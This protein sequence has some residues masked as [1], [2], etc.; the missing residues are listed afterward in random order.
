MN[1][2]WTI[3]GTQAIR[4]AERDGARLRKY[5][6]PIEG[7][8]DNLTGD[9]AREICRRDPSLVYVVV[10]HVGW[11]G[12][13][14]GANIADYFRGTLGG[15]ARSGATYLGPDEDELEPTWSDAQ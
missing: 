15:A 2:I 14:T 12:D 7:Y 11:T 13:A 4:I 9:E 1:N 8:R 3:H 5:A 10:R 6:D